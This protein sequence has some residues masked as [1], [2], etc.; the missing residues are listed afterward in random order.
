MVAANR[1]HMQ[2]RGA[3]MTNHFGAW[4]GEVRFLMVNEIGRKLILGYDFLAQA[5][6]EVYS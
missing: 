1:D 2:V 5:K 3:Y 6:V 4:H